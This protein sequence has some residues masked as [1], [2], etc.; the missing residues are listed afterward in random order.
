M[1]IGLL[2]ANRRFSVTTRRVVT[3]TEPRCGDQAHSADIPDLPR[4]CEMTEN[5]F[6]F[7]L[8]SPVQQYVLTLLPAK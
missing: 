6:I 3:Q 4:H 8:L 7:R 1:L 2:P 5:M